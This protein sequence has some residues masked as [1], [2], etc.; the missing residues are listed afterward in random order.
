MYLTTLGN[1]PVTGSRHAKY[2]LH[3]VATRLLVLVLAI[4]L[5]FSSSKT[6]TMSQNKV[7]SV[8]EWYLGPEGT[9]FFTKRVSICQNKTNIKWFPANAE[10]E[11]YVVFVH[12]FAEHVQRYDAYFRRLAAHNIHILAFDQ[13]GH[14]LTAHKPLA[15][16]DPVIVNWTKEGKKVLIDRNQKHR[17]GGW[18]KAIPDIEFFVKQESERASAKG[19]K[20]FLHG[21]SMVRFCQ[22]TI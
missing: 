1:N 12:G 3:A 2:K 14:G 15:D 13:R 5:S 11:A 8:E 9:P 19:K 7:D 6:I 10:P 22:V 17:T 16:N 18:V 4:S 21:H 20:L